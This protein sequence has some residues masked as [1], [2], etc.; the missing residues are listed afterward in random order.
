MSLI[1]SAPV[2]D[3]IRDHLAG[4]LP[5][6]MTVKV[7]PDTAPAG[8]VAVTPT[9]SPTLVYLHMAGPDKARMLVQITITDTTRER[10]RLAG[11]LARVALAGVDHRDRPLHP[12]VL[13]GYVFDVPTTSGDGHAA[14]E[15]GGHT[16]VE[17]YAI[18]WQYRPADV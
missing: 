7:D 3:C 2:L 5:A 9:T 13:P 6:R 8:M 18:V 11:D 12:L 16:W 17:T 15:T 14:T 1:K 4:L 10:V